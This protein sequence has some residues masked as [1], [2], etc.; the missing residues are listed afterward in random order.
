MEHTYTY[1]SSSSLTLQA[2]EEW[3]TRTDFLTSKTIQKIACKEKL[4][5]D[6]AVVAISAISPHAMQAEQDV[7]SSFIDR[8]GILGGTVGLFM[9]LSIISVIEVGFWIYRVILELGQAMF[10]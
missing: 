8:I 7:S 5:R 2:Q 6:L 3:F 1:Y 4:K 9:G 10:R